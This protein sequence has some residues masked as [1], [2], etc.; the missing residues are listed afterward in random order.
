[1]LS[2]I[3]EKEPRV[4]IHSQP[5][6]R[7]YIKHG[8]TMVG[9][10]HGD[11]VKSAMLPGIMAQEKSEWWGQ[12]KFRYWLKGHLHHSTREEY[13]GVTVEMFRTLAPNDAYSA[14]HGWLS[15]QDMCNITYHEDYGEIARTT[16]SISLLRDL[17]CSKTKS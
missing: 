16:C 13:N 9:A 2:H 15:G 14:S 8:Q 1:M 17:S 7:F 4:I 12:T 5:T 6:T 11:K 10:V 3:Y